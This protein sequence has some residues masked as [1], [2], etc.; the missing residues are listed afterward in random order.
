MLIDTK[1]RAGNWW[2]NGEA[3]FLMAVKHGTHIPEDQDPHR[4]TPVNCRNIFIDGVT[5]TSENAIGAVGSGGNMENVMLSDITASRKPPANLALKG[6][7]FDMAPAPENVPVPEDCAVYI[8][9]APG[10]TLQNVR[11]LPF[12]GRE[13]HIVIE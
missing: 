8:K 2:G 6:R 11:A 10:V 5:C 1:V 3:I 13:Q 4:H 7:V 9:N 12:Q